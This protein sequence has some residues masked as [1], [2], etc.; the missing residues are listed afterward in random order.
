VPDFIKLTSTLLIYYM[1]WF[2]PEKKKE[3]GMLV[4]PAEGAEGI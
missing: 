1:V 4:H 2:H 3:E